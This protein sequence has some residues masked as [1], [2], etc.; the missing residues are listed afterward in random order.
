MR[1]KGRR[2]LR[3]NKAVYVAL[4]GAGL[5]LAGAVFPCGSVLVSAAAVKNPLAAGIEGSPAYAEATASDA[6]V[7]YVE[8][9]GDVR[10]VPEL[11]W[12]SSESGPGRDGG[13]RPEDGTAGSKGYGEEE[14]EGESS[15]KPGFT[16][17]Y[18]VMNQTSVLVPETEILFTLP[19]SSGMY[20]ENADGESRNHELKI[21]DFSPGETREVTLH[22]NCRMKTEEMTLQPIHVE[23]ILRGY[24]L[25][26]RS[27][28]GFLIP[29]LPQSPE[30]QEIDVPREFVCS[31][32]IANFTGSGR[33]PVNAEMISRGEAVRMLLAEQ[34]SGSGSS[35]MHFLSPED[36]GETEE[37]GKN[38]I[39]FLSVLIAMAA[40]YFT[41]KLLNVYSIRKTERLRKFRRK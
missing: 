13:S 32:L 24:G 22:G 18:T 39:Y 11:I 14:N 9:E 17:R 15:H 41:Q 36:S 31:I 5:V 8:I 19:E 12:D 30:I 21:L 25:E 38:R 35:R 27:D 29:S 34:S 16:L 20:F 1:E 2:M 33:A 28:G 10:V 23:I 7:E 37:H 26:H 40:F 6:E 4:L 3:K